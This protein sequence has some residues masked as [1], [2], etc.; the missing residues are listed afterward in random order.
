MARELPGKGSVTLYFDREVYR[1][2]GHRAVDEDKTLPELLKGWV[3]ERVGNPAPVVE[4]VAAVELVQVERP[5][6]KPAP[7]VAT[8]A[9][10][11]CARCG[12]MFTPKNPGAAATARWCSDKCRSRQPRPKE[13]AKKAS[14]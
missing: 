5:T 7:K 8:I 13:R 4:P 6:P 9:T 3:L 14:A 11:A 12:T 2:L 1:Q 10:K